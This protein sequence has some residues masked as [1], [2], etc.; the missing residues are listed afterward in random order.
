[1]F[2]SFFIVS[3]FV[4]IVSLIFIPWFIIRLPEDYFS[5][6]NHPSRDKSSKSF[7]QNIVKNVF[8][9]LLIIMGIIMLITPGPGIFTILM[10][11]M[12][13][14]IPGK[15]KIERWLVKHPSVL[16]SMNWTRKKAGKNPL[17][18]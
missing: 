4:Y 2:K 8:A 11:V 17:V 14:D 1:M 10:G 18:Y 12:L 5:C 7:W 15:Y 13:A 9:F 3:I 6:E 16:K